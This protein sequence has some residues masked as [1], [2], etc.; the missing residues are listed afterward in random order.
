MIIYGAGGHGKV[1]IDI[2]R[3]A[4]VLIR[5]VIDDAVR[6]SE[7]L[8]ITVMDA[9]QFR[10]DNLGVFEYLV[11]IGDNAT[12]ARLFNE[13]RS[14]GG[15]PRSLVHPFSAISSASELGAGIAVCAG[16]VVNPAAVV[17]ENCIINTGASVDHDC[18]VE[19]HCHICPGVRLAG[20]VTIGSMTTV[21]TGA[22]VLPG[23]RISQ[24]CRIGAGAVVT[25]DLPPF[26]V[27]CGVPARVQR[28]L[29][30]AAGE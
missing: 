9:H 30:P 25:R 14:R 10:W 4:G 11:A 28:R 27:A 5:L 15:R 6:D 21:G 3:T 12:R 22:S 29:S 19:A 23:V 20:N 24:G 7:L 16:A 1:V 2:A 26:V 17:H 8:G 18:I 13:L